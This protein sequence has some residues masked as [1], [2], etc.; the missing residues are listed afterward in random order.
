MSIAKEFFDN[1]VLG[2]LN[3]VDKIVNKD[4][5]NHINNS[6]NKSLNFINLKIEK[7]FTTGSNQIDNPNRTLIPK[8]NPIIIWGNSG[9]GKT[10]FFD[11]ILH[12]FANHSNDKSPIMDYVT[13]IAINFGNKTDKF[14]IEFNSSSKRNKFSSK[15]WKDEE[16]LEHLKMYGLINNKLSLQNFISSDTDILN[17]FQEYIANFSNFIEIFY[18]PKDLEVLDLIKNFYNELKLVISEYIRK[19]KFYQIQINNQRD[20]IDETKQKLKNLKLFFNNIEGIRKLLDFLKEDSFLIEC[21]EDIKKIRKEII[22]QDNQISK[23]N[24]LNEKIKNKAKED[25]FLNFVKK[26]YL[27]SQDTCILCNSTL[28]FNNYYFSYKTNKCYLCHNDYFDYKK[29]N[30][31]EL[32]SHKIESDDSHFSIIFNLAKKTKLKANIKEIRNKMKEYKKHTKISEEILGLTKIATPFYREIQ[33]KIIDM[34]NPLP[35]INNRIHNYEESL[36]KFK[37]EENFYYS[38]LEKIKDILTNL[39][40]KLNQ[41]KEIVSKFKLILDNEAKKYY[42]DFCVDLSKFWTILAKEEKKKVLVKNNKLYAV[43]ISD[44]GNIKRN[45]INSFKPK[46]RRLSRSQ[47]EMLR[48]AINLSA[49]KNT[50]LSLNSLPMKTIIFDDPDEKCIP[51]LIKIFNDEFIG[52]LDFQV[53]LITNKKI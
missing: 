21:R 39:K 40:S 8:K 48:Y 27:K 50:Y 5:V 23:I 32:V 12:I 1:S 18:N 16:I 10:T 28:D 44:A 24:A 30:P 4:I 45:I 3:N 29:Y 11:K 43:T 25:N 37:I 13:F 36:K 14:K 22:Y 41:T 49:I 38:E 53:I 42:N 31:Q 47:A 26:E 9:V 7:I 33:S 6:I 15:K 46:V 34:N 19:A 35:I 51:E 2:I 17:H 20:V 52:K